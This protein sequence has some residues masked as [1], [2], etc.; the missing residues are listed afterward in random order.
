LF[1]VK[2]GFLDAL[3]FNSEGLIPVVV[4]DAG[5]GEVLMVAWMNREAVVRSLQT[6]QTWFYSRSRKQLW[7]KGAT[8]GHVQ[9]IRE[10]YHDCD[11]DT[12]LLRVDQQGVACHQGERSC[13]HNRLQQDG[14]IERLPG[15]PGGPPVIEDFRILA[16]L[17]AVIEQRKAELPEGSYTTYLFRSG[18]DKIL[19][20]LGEEAT[21]VVIAAKNHRLE[22]IRYEMADLW[23]HAMV[24]MAHQDL[25]L[26]EVLD[27]LRR[28][29]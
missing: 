1:E 14:E 25:S 24:L 6:G 26:A 12:L 28:R 5:S 15:G 21:E 17:A 23:Y 22:E 10:V 29:R 2:D 13:F 11:A 9:I 19:K 4:Q 18:L 27:E 16:E 8:S 3:K 7:H 20:K